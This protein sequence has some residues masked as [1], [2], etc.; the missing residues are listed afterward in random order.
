MA[1]LRARGDAVACRR[2]AL[3]SRITR[4]P[5]APTLDTLCLPQTEP[6]KRLEDLEFH[7]AEDDAKVEGMKGLFG[8]DSSSSE[9]EEED[10]LR[11]DDA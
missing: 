9:E 11:E 6:K 10:L 8:D 4:R 5:L 3:L 7:T 1:S 2:C